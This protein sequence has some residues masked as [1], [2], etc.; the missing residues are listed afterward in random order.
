MTLNFN[1]PK[2]LSELKKKEMLEAFKKGKSI[3]DLEVRYGLKRVTITKHLKSLID[4]KE[5][6]ILTELNSSKNTVNSLKDKEFINSSDK[7]GKSID[8]NSAKAIEHNHKKIQIK[9]S[10]SNNQSFFEI[11]P[12]NEEFDF[13][14]RKDL[15]SKPLEEFALPGNIFMVVDNSIELNILT[16]SDFPEFGFL[17]ESDQKRKILKLFSNKK[18]AN[19]FCGKNQ[20]VIKVPNGNIFNLASKYLR[21]KGISRIIF[22]D[23]LLSI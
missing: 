11:P 22:D 1:L 14:S 18:T 23:Y 17:P 8:E 20:K 10:S 21:K 7:I 2:I 15:T 9:D 4:I 12:L 16:M 6:K 5:F 3:E 19:S 13:D